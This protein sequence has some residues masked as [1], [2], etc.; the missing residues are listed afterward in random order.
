[1]GWSK[2]R[3]FYCNEMFDLRRRNEGLNWSGTVSWRVVAWWSRGWLLQ[4]SVAFFVTKS[5]VSARKEYERVS[6]RKEYERCLSNH[7][8]VCF[9]NLNISAGTV[10]NFDLSL[11][12][13]FIFLA[14]VVLRDPS[15]LLILEYEGL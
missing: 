10:N 9:S 12:S 13:S 1:M 14:R 7:L 5:W 3:Y 4:S 2:V 11:F 15:H 6:A 8:V